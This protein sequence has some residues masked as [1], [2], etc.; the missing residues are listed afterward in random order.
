M[1]IGTLYG[2]G[3]GTGDPELITVK[4]LKIL[5]QVPLVAFPSGMNHQPGIAEKIIAPWL[6]SEQ[7]QLALEFPYTQEGTL[8][9]QAWEKAAGTVWES[10]KI[11][12]DVAFACEGDVSFYS[13]FNYL[14][15]TIAQRHPEVNIER[16]PGVCSP[17]AAASVLGIP[18]TI[19]QQKLAILPTLY[20]VADLESVLT[21]ADVVVLMKVSSVYHRVWPIL[22]KLNLLESS[23][24]VER[25]TFPNQTLY[26]DLTPYPQL[27]LSYFSVLIVKNQPSTIAHLK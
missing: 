22:Q 17:S 9:Q 27:E 7:T 3:V 23:S 4:G 6:R 16:V 21:W 1:N 14:A 26:Q 2:I 25:A 8:L 15:Q 24:I 11:G 12:K 20:T 18:L 13:T 19:R 5:Q 10:L